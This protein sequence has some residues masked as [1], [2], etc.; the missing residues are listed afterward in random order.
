MKI[1]VTGGT[2][3][4][5]R[6]V[7]RALLSNDHEVIALSRDPARIAAAPGVTPRQVDL[8][9]LDSILPA[10]ED[11][12]AGIHCAGAG[13]SA[14]AATQQRSNVQVSRHVAAAAKRKKHLARLIAISSAAVIEP[15]DSTYRQYKVG[16]EAALRTVRL[17]L[18]LLRPTLVLGPPDES[19]EIR[20]LAE[21]MK[22]GTHWVPG[23]GRNKIQPVHVDDVARAA[24]AALGRPDSIGKEITI[25]GPENGLAYRD[26]LLAI[27]DATGGGAKIGSVPIAPM[28]LAAIPLGLVGRAQSIRAQIAYYSNDHL[29]PIEP[30]M[31][32]LG[33]APQDYQEAIAACFR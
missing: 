29:Y 9:E 7:I 10:I 20:G 26:L 22:A 8:M 28:R 25:A 14:D 15:V 13:P 24:V 5:G 33:F 4:I 31:R 3:L 12:E 11:C 23:G 1:Y 30:A 18:T 21:R 19:A 17:D 32:L 27:R 16:Q 2:G 6:H